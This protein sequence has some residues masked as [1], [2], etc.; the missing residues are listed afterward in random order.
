MVWAMC[1]SHLALFEEQNSKPIL[2]RIYG[3]NHAIDQRAIQNAV[4]I[5]RYGVSLVRNYTPWDKT[6]L[7][8]NPERS[9][10]AEYLHRKG[11]RCLRSRHGVH[12]LPRVAHINRGHLDN[13]I[14]KADRPLAE[15]E[16]WRRTSEDGSGATGL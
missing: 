7:P 9:D 13:Y 11:K 1:Y 2:N 4:N 6:N 14:P 10:S 8:R 12:P 3:H 5:Y 15:S 16:G